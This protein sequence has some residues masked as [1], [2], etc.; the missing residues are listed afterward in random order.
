MPKP[1]RCHLWKREG[2]TANDLRDAFEILE[3]FESSSHLKRHLL[4]CKDCGQ[5]YFYEFYEEIDWER[6]HDPQYQTYI[7]VETK[8]QIEALKATDNY[9][10]LRYTPRLQKDWPS[11]AER[12]QVEWVGRAGEPTE[13]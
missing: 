12:P 6:G 3:T 5:L 1:M 7:P 4:R 2:L 10:L 8:D 9:T 11:D 13:E